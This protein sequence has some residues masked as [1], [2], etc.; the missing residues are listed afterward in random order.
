MQGPKWPFLL[1]YGSRDTRRID[2][3]QVDGLS[4]DPRVLGR[5]RECSNVQPGIKKSRN[6]DDISSIFRVSGYPDTIFAN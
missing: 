5:H 1:R 4:T 2:F 3:P 6:I